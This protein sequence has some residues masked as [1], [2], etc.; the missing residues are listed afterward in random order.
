MKF[1]C[2]IDLSARDCQGVFA[3]CNGIRAADESWSVTTS[4]PT[5]WPRPPFMY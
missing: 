2:G 3:N 1:Y 4:S 5:N